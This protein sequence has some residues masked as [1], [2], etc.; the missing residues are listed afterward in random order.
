MNETL[1]SLSYENLD[2]LM[3]CLSCVKKLYPL[4]WNKRKKDEETFEKIREA[5]FKAFYERRE[6]GEEE[7]RSEESTTT[8]GTV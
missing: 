4:S 1:L 2:V 8:E 6:N 7:S 3:D 5:Y